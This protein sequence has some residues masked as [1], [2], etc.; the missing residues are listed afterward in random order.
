[1]HDLFKK[2]IT[3]NYLILPKIVKKKENQKNYHIM[4]Q[5]NF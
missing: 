4:S 2:I 5:F 1:M 3:E